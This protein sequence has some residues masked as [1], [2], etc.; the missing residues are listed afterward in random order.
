[1]LLERTKLSAQKHVSHHG[2]GPGARLRAPGGV[3]GQRFGGVQE[4]EPPEA[5][6][7][8]F[9]RYLPLGLP[10]AASG[11][12]AVL[13]ISLSKW[14]CGEQQASLKTALWLL[15]RCQ[16]LHQENRKK[17]NKNREVFKITC[18][19]NGTKPAKNREFAK[20]GCQN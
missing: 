19:F 15:Q 5:L 6:G 12:C 11:A 3:Q 8:Y 4:A 1:M 7:F 10:S 9:L 14:Q 13:Q 18:N 2:W 20:F 17:S 16:H